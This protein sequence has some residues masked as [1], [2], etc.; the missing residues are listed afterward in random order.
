MLLLPAVLSSD[1][2]YHIFAETSR[3]VF[4]I[5]L[6]LFMNSVNLISIRPKAE[7]LSPISVSFHLD[8]EDIVT[9]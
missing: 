5:E 2:V 8:Y 7:I 4:L 9:K 1:I 3:D 6:N